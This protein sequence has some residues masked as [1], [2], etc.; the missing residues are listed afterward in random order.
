M[1]Q[2]RRYTMDYL[3]KKKKKTTTKKFKPHLL[4]TEFS[5]FDGEDVRGEGEG[6]GLLVVYL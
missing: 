3:K 2:N 5:L 6:K 1:E 4:H